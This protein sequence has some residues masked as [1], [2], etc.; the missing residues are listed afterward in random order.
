[1]N[2]TIKEITPLTHKDCFSIFSRVKKSFDFPLHFHEEYELKLIINGA[3]AK[4][5][6]GDFQKQ[7]TLKEIVKFVSMTDVSFSRF[8]S[9][10]TGNT[11]CGY[12]K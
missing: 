6:I 3:G 5:I 12:L 11:F 9:K 4:R 8:I 1:M 2:N 10:R 7:I